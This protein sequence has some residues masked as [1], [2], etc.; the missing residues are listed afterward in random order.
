[1]AKSGHIHKLRRHRYKTGSSIYFCTLPDCN[2]KVSTELVLGKTSICNRCGKPF[3]LNEYSIRLAKPHCDAC[4]R[5]KEPLPHDSRNS[6]ITV[7]KIE[8]Q[9]AN[10]TVSKL[11]NTLTSLVG[12]ADDELL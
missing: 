11:Q 5:R 1:M 2:Y 8:V 7:K 4:H 6:P 3:V 10:D 9:I 12:S